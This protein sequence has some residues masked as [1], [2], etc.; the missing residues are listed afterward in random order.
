MNA[1]TKLSPRS[2]T[3]ADKAEKLDRK[4]T[5]APLVDVLESASELVVIADLPGVA[6]D[7]MHIHFDKNR[8]TIE[9]KRAQPKFAERTPDAVLPDYRRTFLVPQGIDGDRISADL[10]NGVLTVHLPKQSAREPRRI[11]INSA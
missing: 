6:K 4:P 11:P 1:E 3:P 5:A 8:L 10:S 2:E 9:G 7:N